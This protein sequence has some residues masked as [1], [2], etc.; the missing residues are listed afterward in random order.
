MTEL[1]LKKKYSFYGINE[2]WL[3]SDSLLKSS[4]RSTQEDL[5]LTRKVEKESS[6]RKLF[7]LGQ[8]QSLQP[9]VGG[10]Y[11]CIPCALQTT[12]HIKEVEWY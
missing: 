12:S 3:E 6:L 8:Q 2:Q 9:K 4:T 5:F 7:D 11:F 1:T 10:H